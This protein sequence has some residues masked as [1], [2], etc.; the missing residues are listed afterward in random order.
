MF[1]SILAE[2]RIPFSAVRVWF[3]RLQMPV[4]RVAWPSPSSSA[5]WSTRRAS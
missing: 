2:E 5:R 1:Q 4:L 3:A